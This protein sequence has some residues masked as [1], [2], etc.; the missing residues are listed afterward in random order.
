MQEW[1]QRSLELRRS[2]ATTWVIHMVTD[3]IQ[4]GDGTGDAKQDSESW[5]GE[6]KEESHHFS[7]SSGV[8]EAH[9][10]GLYKVRPLA[11]VVFVWQ[12]E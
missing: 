12:E 5:Q 10:R 6:Q 11:D 1:K 9:E 2:G 4:N 7:W 8:S 3:V